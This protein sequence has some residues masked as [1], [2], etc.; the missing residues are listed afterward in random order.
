MP[1][2][3]LV[4]T[5]LRPDDPSPLLALQPPCR[6]ERPHS[7]AETLEQGR[8]RAEPGVACQPGCCLSGHRPHQGGRG[9]AGVL[10]VTC[11]E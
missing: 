2:L 9:E 4:A 10:T 3:E 11:M 8:W 1:A 5:L 6:G 7:R